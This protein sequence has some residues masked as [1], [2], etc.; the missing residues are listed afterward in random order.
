MGAPLDTFSPILSNTFIQGL[1]SELAT[2][3]RQ[4]DQLSEQ[5][6]DLHPDMIKV[7]TAIANLQRQL[8]AEMTQGCRRRSERLPGGEDERGWAR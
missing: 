2:L 6:G 5:L 8:K 1:K 7:N 3:E 4:R